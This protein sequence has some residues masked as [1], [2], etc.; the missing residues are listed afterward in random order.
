MLNHRHCANGINNVTTCSVLQFFN[1][2]TL[3]YRSNHGWS[4]LARPSRPNQR[5]FVNKNYLTKSQ[6]LAILEGDQS[7]DDDNLDSGSEDDLPIDNSTI[8]S[9]LGRWITLQRLNVYCNLFPKTILFTTLGIYW[10][11]I[12]W[13]KLSCKQTSM[14]FNYFCDEKQRKS[15]ALLRA[16]MLIGMNYLFS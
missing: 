9:Y 14:R 3:W 11:T 6:L 10:P 7:N 12:Y 16:R 2:I 4:K 15:L 13:M 8:S 5:N 1:S